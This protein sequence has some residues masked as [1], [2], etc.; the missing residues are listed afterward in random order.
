MRRAIAAAFVFSGCLV[1]QHWSQFR[2]P[3]AS[4]VAE[5]AKPPVSF[6]VEKSV[7]LRWKTPIPGIA[8]SSP[9][10]WADKVFVT[11]AISSDPKAS[12]RHGLFGDVEPS[13]DTSKHAWK[14]YCEN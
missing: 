8:V 11:T 10:V 1:A 3:N 2:G 14:V 6:D 13:T 4:G 12:F 9:I 5:G 7:N